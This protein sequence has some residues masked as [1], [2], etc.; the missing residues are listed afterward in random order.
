MDKKAAIVNGF[1]NTALRPTAPAE[2][3]QQGRDREGPLGGL[4]L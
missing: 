2:V 3:A 4:N 1:D